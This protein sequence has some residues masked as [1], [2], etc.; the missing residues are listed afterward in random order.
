MCIAF[1]S[2][3]YGGKYHGLLVKG[4]LGSTKRKWL[5]WNLICKSRNEP[6]FQWSWA[7]IKFKKYNNKTCTMWYSFE[8]LIDIASCTRKQE[9]CA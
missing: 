8:S 2:S 7:K 5:P 4:L 3:N 6:W 9:N 1:T